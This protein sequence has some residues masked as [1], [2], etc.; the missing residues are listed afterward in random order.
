MTSLSIGAV[1]NGAR[2]RALAPYAGADSPAIFRFMVDQDAP[3]GPIRIDLA[4]SAVASP[5]TC[6]ILAVPSGAPTPAAS[7][8]IAGQ[9]NDGGEAAISAQFSADEDGAVTLAVP[10][11]APGLYDFYALAR[12]DGGQSVLGSA[13]AVS[14]TFTAI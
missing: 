8:V 4:F 9:L 11:L 5:L 6:F 3:D 1:L 13:L 12:S 7:E 2:G 14:L 10:S